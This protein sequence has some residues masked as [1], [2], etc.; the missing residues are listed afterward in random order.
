MNTFRRLYLFFALIATHAIGAEL[1]PVA[2]FE[3]TV[4]EIDGRVVKFLSGS[5]WL[6]DRE[7]VALPLG[8]A[9]VVC[10]GAA[11]VFNK[12][13][14]A[15][16]IRALPQQG[17]FMYRGQTVGAKLVSGV[18]LLTDGLLGQVTQAHGG[19]AILET[20]DGSLWSVPRY[21]QYDTGYWLPPYPVIIYKSQ[22]HLLNLKEGKKIW[23]DKKVK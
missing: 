2:F 17:A 22:L 18:F 13:K 23:L 11:P 19:G 21:D 12:D 16:Y 1:K 10:S 9:T 14:M 3:D 15:E 5:T 6:L 20:D 4:M 7:I 8:Q